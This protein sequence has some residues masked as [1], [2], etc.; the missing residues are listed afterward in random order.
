M[1]VLKPRIVDNFAAF[2][3]GIFVLGAVGWRA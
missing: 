3:A 1:S 2:A